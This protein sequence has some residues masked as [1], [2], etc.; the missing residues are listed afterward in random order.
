MYDKVNTVGELLLGTNNQS[1][2]YE[3]NRRSRLHSSQVS[4]KEEYE[5]KD[6]IFSLEFGQKNEVKLE[7]EMI[8]G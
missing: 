1:I 6:D 7:G 2:K 8:K 5:E 3:D 4:V